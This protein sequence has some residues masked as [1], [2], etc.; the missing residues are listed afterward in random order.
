[1]ILSQRGRDCVLVADDQLLRGAR[2]VHACQREGL[3]PVIVFTTDGALETLDRLD[4]DAVVAS[5]QLPSGLLGGLVPGVRR[6]TRAPLVMLCAKGDPRPQADLRVNVDEPTE[7]IAWHVRRLLPDG[8][9]Q[10][11]QHM[12]G[13]LQLEPSTQRAWW[14]GAL[15]PLTTQQFALLRRL[16]GAQGAVVTPAE[17]AEAV[18][19]HAGWQDTERIR[20]HVLRIRRR[21]AAADCDGAQILATVRGAGFRLRDTSTAESPPG[22]TPTAHGFAHVP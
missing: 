16:V 9:A 4:V 6:R 11:H 19:G 21:L 22:A 18:Y 2:L 15:L 7:A 13:A 14:G 8:P 3:I 12:W 1:M 17:L 5:A 20:A 10:R